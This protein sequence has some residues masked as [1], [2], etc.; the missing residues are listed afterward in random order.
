MN[1]WTV[2]AP[3]GYRDR[4]EQADSFQVVEGCLLFLVGNEVNAAYSPHMWRLVIRE[5]DGMAVA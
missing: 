3:D 1:T 2:I 5:S 4:S